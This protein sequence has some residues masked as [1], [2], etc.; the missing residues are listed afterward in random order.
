MMFERQS[1]HAR[2]NHYAPRRLA[3]LE[4][5]AEAMCQRMRKMD[6]IEDGFTLR[7]SNKEKIN[8]FDTK[9]P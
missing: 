4:P 3:Y 7:L 9:A 5:L 8:L 2:L 6:K 1:F